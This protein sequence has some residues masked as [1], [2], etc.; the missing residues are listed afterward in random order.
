MHVRNLA[1]VLIALVALPALLAGCGPTHTAGT[2]G[3]AARD[4]SVLSIAQLPEE[5]H[6][7]ISAIQFDGKGD[8]YKIGKSRDFYLLP[9]EH[10]ASFTLVARVPKMEGMGAMAGLASWL[11]P[12]NAVTIPSPGDIPLGAV[13]AGKTYE[14]LPTAGGDGG[15]EGFEKM[16]MDGKLSLVREKAK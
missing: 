9:G 11:V 13:A 2:R 3:V 5:A 10:T 6:V 4:L 7:Q 16:L 1:A 12:K 15:A 14:L 8:Q